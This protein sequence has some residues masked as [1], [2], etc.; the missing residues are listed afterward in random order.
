MS[1]S[2]RQKAHNAFE[3]FTTEMHTQNLTTDGLSL[4]KFGMNIDPP[5]DCVSVSQQKLTQA[6]LSNIVVNEAK[7]K[8][9]R[10]VISKV[11]V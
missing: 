8:K 5:S 6:N 9:G 4:D 10:A 3:D 7:Q 2:S 11:F 1:F